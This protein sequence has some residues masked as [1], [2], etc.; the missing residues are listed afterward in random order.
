MRG[1]PASVFIKS[2]GRSALP[3][4]LSFS[5]KQPL[6]IYPSWPRSGCQESARKDFLPS[7]TRPDARERVRERGLAWR[8]PA[9]PPSMLSAAANT[10][11]AATLRV[12]R[13]LP[14]LISTESERERERER[15]RS[16]RSLPRLI[17][18]APRFRMNLFSIH[19]LLPT[20]RPDSR[21]LS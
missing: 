8:P 1:G 17:L 10:D 4:S 16:S 15:E 21:S 13:Y 9:S 20:A 5:Q 2:V 19:R 18:L 11:S 14:P 12:N 7:W 6:E 3:F